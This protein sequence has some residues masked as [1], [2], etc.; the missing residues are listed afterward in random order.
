LKLALLEGE[1][2][3]MEYPVRV[4]AFA[5]VHSLSLFFVSVLLSYLDVLIMSV[6]HSTGESG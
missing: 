5:S 4:A 6:F 1:S 2:G 3:V